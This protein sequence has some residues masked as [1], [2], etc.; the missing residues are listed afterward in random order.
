MYNI[1]QFMKTFKERV[2]T[3]YNLEYGHTGTL[4]EGRFYSGIVEK[5]ADVMQIVSAYIDLNACRAGILEH[6]HDWRCPRRRVC[7]RRRKGG[8]AV[9]VARG[10][11]GKASCPCYTCTKV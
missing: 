11:G 1:S 10:Q 9:W 4:W 6:A 3:H 8:V 7:P 2:S 5:D